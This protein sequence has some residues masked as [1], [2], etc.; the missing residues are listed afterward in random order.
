MNLAQNSDYNIVSSNEVASII[1][2]FTPEMISDVVE[3]SLE[4]KYRSY[5]PELANIVMSIEENY[6]MA[7]TGLPEFSSEIVSQRY[8]IYLQIIQ[9][10]C[11]AHNLQFIG[12]NN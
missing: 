12:M 9:Q 10:V 6:R 1:C 11:S 5:S 8:N 3:S 7:Q 2:R 4:S